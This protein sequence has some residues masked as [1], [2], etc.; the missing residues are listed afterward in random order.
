MKRKLSNI[1][2]ILDGNV[3][4]LVSLEGSF[5]LDQMRSALSRVQRRHP[6]LRA[7][8]R[9]ESDGLYYEDDSAPQIPL[10][11]VPGAS[12]DD[13][14]RECE[15]ELTTEFAYDQPQLRA[16]WLKSEGKSDL[17]FTT[18]HR[19]CDGKSIFILVK[20]ILQSLYS[21]RELVPYAPIGVQDIIGGYRPVHTGKFKLQLRML[22]GLLHLI[23]GARRAPE[24]M[25]YSSEWKANA[26]FL[27]ALKARGKAERVSVHAALVVALERALF[28]VLGKR[29]PKHIDNQ[30]DP[31]RGNF[32]ALKND[33]LFF[34]GGS[35]KVRTR[36]AADA[37]FWATARAIY[38]DMKG[39]IDQELLNIPR[40]LHFIE[41]LRPVT[42]G[43]VRSIMRFSEALQFH[44]RSSFALSNIGNIMIDDSRAPFRL[45]DLRLYVHSFKTRAL[46]LVTYTVNGE[47]YFYCVSHD[48]CL[49]PNQVD[50]LKREFM[51]ELQHQVMRSEH[52]PASASHFLIRA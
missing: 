46:G 40:R 5:S 26:I 43:Q 15:K 33:A 6:A 13:R 37:E 44:R 35:F 39:Q 52:D 25:E 24:K 27:D 14:R 16:V 10:H 22:N 23:P 42:D 45:K 11:I 30:I 1:E 36:E 41:A 19:I 38:N 51:A 2:H 7:L 9:E 3:M 31:R 32:S 18:S 17:L 47:M 29:L 21:G 48:K 34:G 20:E 8:I 50:A 28:A 4:C 49:N 12:E